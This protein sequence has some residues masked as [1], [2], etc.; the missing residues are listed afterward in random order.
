MHCIVKLTGKQLFWV[1]KVIRLLVF[2]VK[3][4]HLLNKFLIFWFLC[5]LNLNFWPFVIFWKK[6]IISKILLNYFRLC[7]LFGQSKSILFLS[8]YICSLTQKEMFENHRKMFKMLWWR[9]Y[10]RTQ[11]LN[12]LVRICIQFVRNNFE[13]KD[14]IWSKLI[15]L[16]QHFVRKLTQSCVKCQY[17]FIYNSY[18]PAILNEPLYAVTDSDLV[19]M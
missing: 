8:I 14:I 16:P 2:Y 13:Y 11:W 10:D 17:N 12:L 1:L 19:K 7:I 15:V 18:N 9:F 6:K 3:K 4:K 5:V